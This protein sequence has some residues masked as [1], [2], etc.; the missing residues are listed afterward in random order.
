MQKAILLAAGS[1]RRAERMSRDGLYRRLVNRFSR[2]VWDATH[3]W[4]P[5]EPESLGLSQVHSDTECFAPRSDLNTRALIRQ[6]NDLWAEV[7]EA[8]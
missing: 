5:S 2:A 1:F 8:L 4:A 7:K 6:S 3:A